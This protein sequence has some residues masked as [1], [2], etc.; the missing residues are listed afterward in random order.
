MIRDP[1]ASSVTMAAQP[2]PAY[3]PPAPGQYP[4]TGQVHYPPAGQYPPAGAPPP[5]Q[6]P[7]VVVTTQPAFFGRYPVSMTCPSCHAQ[8]QTAVDYQAGTM[9]WIVCFVLFF[10]TAICCFIPFLIDACKDAVHHCPACKVFIGRK[11]ALS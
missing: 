7:V 1:A 4:P 9:T 5:P 8:I 6:P 10:F 3:P 11:N 2:P